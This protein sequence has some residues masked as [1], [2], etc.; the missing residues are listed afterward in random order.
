MNNFLRIIKSIVPCLL[1]TL[2][3]GFCYAFS[4]FVPQISEAM[5][6]GIN[7]VRFV[8]C[9]NIFFL[10]IGAAFFGNVVEKHIKIA[11][12]ISTVLLY[13][14]LLLTSISIAVKS[15]PMLY[16]GFG[17]FCGL[18][19]GCG[20]V[21]PVKNLLL[22]WKDTNKKGLVAAISIISFGLGSTLCSY[23]YKILSNRFDIAEV[24][25]ALSIIYVIPMTVATILI[26]KP[27]EAKIEASNYVSIKLKDLLE[28]NFFT[29]AWLFMFLN[30]SM[31]LIIIGSCSSILTDVKLSHNMVI[32]VMMLC[33]L[34]NGGGR[35]VFPVISDF[36]K[37]RINIWVLTLIIECVV[38]IVPMF[39]YALV[40]ITVVLINATY[41]SAFATLPSVLYDKYGSKNLSQI[42]GLVLSA[43]GF[44]S[45]FAYICL[46][47]ITN[48]CTGYYYF[49]YLLFFV[50]L[51]N[52][53]NVMWIKKN[54]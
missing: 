15:I 38:M 26:D 8:F 9:I 46:A 34:F 48:F 43:W 53:I 44:A 23:L 52:L 47:L 32:I 4:L 20:Y 50:Y 16:V 7:T 13:M 28:D 24:F 10:G 14:G 2:C 33:G 5:N 25:F 37:N 41:G 3:I 12:T 30:I 39:V 45:V 40:P 51:I 19:E 49:S 42:H 29:R 35:L 27:K 54:M 31:G 17:L 21:T 36:M 1:L 18:A 22:W 11:S 6:C